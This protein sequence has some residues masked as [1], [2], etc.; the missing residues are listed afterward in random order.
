MS[1]CTSSSAV[2]CAWES[3]QRRR[4]IAPG[5]LQ[6]DANPESGSSC[7]DDAEFGMQP[8]HDRCVSSAGLMPPAT[9]RVL[10]GLQDALSHPS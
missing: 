4:A 7:A 9:L 3:R 10:D 6:P 2:R 8:F 1:R 5:P